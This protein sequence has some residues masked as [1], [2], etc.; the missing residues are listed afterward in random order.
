MGGVSSE[1][2]NRAG[3]RSNGL[4][5]LGRSC[6]Y[7]ARL[8]SLR[9]DFR[10]IP[11]RVAV[12]ALAALV[13]LAGGGP[14]A[15]RCDASPRA[16]AAA[17]PVT[18][19]PAFPE[20]LPP[21]LRGVYVRVGAH[22]IHVVDRGAGPPVVLLH[23]FGGWV[24]TFRDV[25]GPLAEGRRVIALDLLGFGL[26][27]KPA[28]GDY[29]LQ[30]EA[31]IVFA[32]L[33]SLGIGRVDVV[34]HSYGGG[35]AAAMGLSAPAR[36]R[37]VTLANSITLKYGRFSVADGALCT[38]LRSPILR[39]PALWIAAPRDA[40]F[41][42]IIHEGYAHPGRAGPEVLPGFLYPYHLPGAR[43]A[44]PALALTAGAGGRTP[45]VYPQKLTMPVFVLWGREDPWFTWG[46]GYQLA[47]R[48]PG[49][50]FAVV[51][52]AGHLVFDEEPRQCVRLL[53][54][55]L[56]GLDARGVR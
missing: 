56:D 46:R 16:V 2:N 43:A 39:A 12:A 20:F 10:F 32:V 34:G 37:S 52:D 24:W 28:D 6:G 8:M 50:S 35:V 30:A 21:A 11:R 9:P 25:V 48:I 40:D 51:P 42:Q 1:C 15:R 18:G 14:G 22:R 44:L 45:P 19:A 49:S 31:A 13:A 29:S 53:R 7:T 23:G 33:D 54:G 3:T 47:A 26:S 5:V 55:F 4:P 41:A 17:A 38:L 36:V 27:D